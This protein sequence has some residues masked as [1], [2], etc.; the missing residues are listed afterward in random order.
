MQRKVMLTAG[1]AVLLVAVAVSAPSSATAGLDRLHLG[2]AQQLDPVPAN[3]PARGMIFNGLER[4]PDAVCSTGLKV[5]GTNLCTHG[6]DPAPKGVDINKSV[7]PVGGRVAPQVVECAGDGNSG[8]RTQVIYARSSDVPDQYATYLASIRTW[9]E[10]ADTIYNASAAETGGS[11]RIR[12]VHD[13]SCNVVVANA[14]MTPTGDDDF[15]NTIAELQALGFN[16][17]DRKYMIFADATVYCGIGTFAWAG[18]S[19]GPDNVSNG[20]PSYGRSDAGCW[21]G[22]VAAHEHM[23]NIGGVQLS[24][25]FTS[26]GAHC[27]DEYDLMCYSDGPG[28]T[29]V[30]MCPDPA[31][32]ERFD[33]N[34]ND[35]YSTNPPVG[36]YLRDH[37]NTADSLYLNGGGKW[38]YVWAD[39]PGA[40]SYTPSAS[41]Q[42][43]S[44][45]ASNT[46]TRSSAGVYS[47]KFPNLGTPGGTVDV[48]AYGATGHMCKVAGWGSAGS[49]LFVSVRCFTTAGVAADATFTA[50]FTKPVQNPGEIGYV[51]ADQPSNPAYTPSL[52]YQ[53][54]S[55]GV[56]NTITRSGVGTYRVYLPWLGAAPNGHVKVTAYGSDS[57]FCKVSGWSQIGGVRTVNVLCFTAAGAPVDTYYTMSYVNSISVLGVNGAAAGYVWADQPS[58]PAYTPSLP[59]QFNSSG[60]VNT[61]TRGPAGW[62][63]VSMP[64]IGQPNGTVHVT[65]YG[66]GTARCKVTGWSAGGGTLNAGV[67]CTDL[68]GVPVDTTYNLTYTR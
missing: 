58:N 13:A 66:G 67:L 7:A 32:D 46:I 47:V 56:V 68:A 19:P 11:R 1:C 9:A 37:W 3:D 8:L 31:H 30:Y 57:N 41:Y 4:V 50:A 17:T 43:N 62:Y 15:G 2:A 53:F 38:G 45:G 61:I 21:T 65:A 55:S 18:D 51:F 64:G 29:M 59:Y 63:T 10:A 12:Y 44:S 40:A 60:A 34:H 5:S 42:R 27:V 35:Y 25:P 16:R 24:A 6:P 23:H 54:N 52:S 26:G 22:A 36:T 14:V 39:Q 33:C 20:G 48:T 28:V 49:D